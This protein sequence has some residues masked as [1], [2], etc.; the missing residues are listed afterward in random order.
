M[1]AVEKGY[2]YARHSARD[3]EGAELTHGGAQI[4]R[5]ANRLQ[6]RPTA[7]LLVVLSYVGHQRLSSYALHDNIY[8]QA[9]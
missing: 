4:L 7:L 5:R 8:A 9:P 2:A 6:P 3:G 1:Q